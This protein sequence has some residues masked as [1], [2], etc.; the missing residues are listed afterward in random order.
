M[1]FFSVSLYVSSTISIM[2]VLC[3]F[4]SAW[5]SSAWV[6]PHEQHTSPPSR[7][8]RVPGRGRVPEGNRR[9]LWHHSSRG[10]RTIGNGWLKLVPPKPARGLFIFM[11]AIDIYCGITAT[12]PAYHTEWMVEIS[13]PNP[14]RGLFKHTKKGMEI[15]CGIIAAVASVPQGIDG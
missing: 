12:V 3:V 7:P 11:H 4:V 15:Y 8:R 5:S 1:T 9:L 10:Q 13:S 14:T 2:I 6:L